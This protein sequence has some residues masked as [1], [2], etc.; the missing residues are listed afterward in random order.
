MYAAVRPAGPAPMITTCGALV[1]RLSE[2]SLMSTVIEDE[3]TAMRGDGAGSGE[4]SP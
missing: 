1:G 4:A 3:H 2:E